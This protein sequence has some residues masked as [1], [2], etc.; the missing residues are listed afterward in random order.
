MSSREVKAGSMEVVSIVDPFEM[1]WSVR[2]EPRLGTVR[3]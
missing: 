2:L 1:S 3:P